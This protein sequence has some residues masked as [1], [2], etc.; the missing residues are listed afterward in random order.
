MTNTLIRAMAE[1][2]EAEALQ[3]ARKLLDVK[4]DPMSILKACTRAMETVGE[5]FEKGEYFLPQL[6][7]AGA[8]LNQISEMIKPHIKEGATSN[9]DRGRVLIG[10][11][12]GDIHDIGKN[13][14]TFLLECNGFEVKDIGIDQ[15]PQQFVAAI[16]DFKPQVVGMS[17]LLTLAFESMKETVLEIEK[18]GL[19]D[20][21]RIMIGGAQVTEQ[22]QNHT[23]ADAFGPDAMAAVRL[24]RQ[25]MEEA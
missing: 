22:V 21:L 10:T 14:V 8:I 12:K 15:H 20:K 4:T 5:R 25:W 19:R 6:L 24:V 17:G 7:M 11:V 18:A 13:M 2:Q 9:A 1:M 23:G 3:R 16:K